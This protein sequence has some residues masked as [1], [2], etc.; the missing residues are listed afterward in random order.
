MPDD[1]SA[2]DA[3]STAP[4]AENPGDTSE[5][6]TPGGADT[7]APPRRRRRRALA[8]TAAAVAALLVAGTG[9]SYAYYRSLRANMVR[10]D[11]D[12]ALVE[13]ERPDKIGDDLNIL[14]IGSDGREGGNAAYGGR[15]FVGER[16]DAL[17]L[18]HISPDGGVQVVNFPRDSLVQIPDCAP[19]GETE[20][21][22]SYYGMINA[23]LFH[24]GPPCVVKTIESLTDVRI[25]HFAHLSFVGFR[26]MVEAIGGVEMCIPEPMR[27]VR[28]QL[29]LEAG[30]QRLDGEEALA[31]VRAR[32]EIGDGGDI[33]RI[34][35]QQMF[36]GAL[37]DE[38]TGSGVLTDPRKTTALLEAVTEHTGTDD[39]FDLPTMIS[40]GS[41]LA[42]VELSD[43]AFYTVPWQQA[44]FDPNRVVWDPEL[45]AELFAAI[46]NDRPVDDQFLVTGGGAE[47]ERDGAAAPAPPAPG[48]EPVAPGESTEAAAPSEAAVSPVSGQADGT[49]PAGR[50][51]GRD[52]TSNPCANGLG[53]GTGDAADTAGAAG[54]RH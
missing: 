25:D 13:E 29:D 22:E 5:S 4:E 48:A 37:A 47:E 17:M 2:D 3:A 31:F 46:K 19:Y 21:T 10:H 23:A 14:F 36:L 30:R 11:L 16:S 43:I 15:D 8:W 26:D 7:P 52:A 40:I 32:Y 1:A 27:D 38:V 45:S 41:T 49:D 51:Q 39:D 34:D 12:A 44:P 35:R 6:G 9:T 54:A 20:G 53:D 42:G 50:V 33:G 28:A 18:A 24:G